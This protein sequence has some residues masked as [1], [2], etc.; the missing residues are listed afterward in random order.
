MALVVLLRLLLQ[1]GGFV[2]AQTAAVVHLPLLPGAHV[3]HPEAP[4][5]VADAQGS[6]SPDSRLLGTGMENSNNAAATAIREERCICMVP[7]Q[8]QRQPNPPRMQLR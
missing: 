6:H 5:L 1:E 3:C 7:A 8:Q 2:L 4:G